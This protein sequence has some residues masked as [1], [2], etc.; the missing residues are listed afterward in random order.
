MVYQKHLFRGNTSKANGKPETNKG[1]V[2]LGTRMPERFR[3]LLNSDHLH[4]DLKQK[5]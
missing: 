2:Q 5:M 3:L 1:F 4:F